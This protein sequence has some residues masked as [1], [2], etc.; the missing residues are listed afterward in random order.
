MSKSWSHFFPL[1]WQVLIEHLLCKSPSVTAVTTQKWQPQ[2]L[3]Q[4]IFWGKIY[5]LAVCQDMVSRA[6]QVLLSSLPRYQMALS[7]FPWPKRSI[8]L[9]TFP[10]GYVAPPLSSGHQSRINCATSSTS[11]CHLS[12][13]NVLTAP[14]ANAPAVS[15]S[16]WSASHREAKSI[17]SSATHNPSGTRLH[18]HHGYSSD[19]LQVWRKP[20]LNTTNRIS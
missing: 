17:Q 10:W 14:Q 18:F 1:T 16:S 9:P 5:S 7:W 13:S 11:S 8:E 20:R 15:A 4:F 6:I 3:C 19:K 12:I 2:I